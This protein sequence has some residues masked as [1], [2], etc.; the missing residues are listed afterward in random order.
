MVALG[1][2]IVGDTMYGGRVLHA[3][4]FEESADEFKFARQALHAYEI[5]FVHPVTLNTM[6]LQAPVPA[7]MSMLLTIL[8]C[9]R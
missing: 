9:E 4:S 2:P 6:T 7:D 1:H 5:T 8:R 3:P